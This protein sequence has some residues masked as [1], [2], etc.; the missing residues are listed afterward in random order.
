MV[1]NVIPF[2]GKFFAES[3]RTSQRRS[4][5]A[6]E[7]ALRRPRFGT[8]A[9]RPWEALSTPNTALSLPA[10]IHLA[11]AHIDLEI[12][13]LTARARLHRLMSKALG[14]NN[15]SLSTNAYPA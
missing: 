6:E 13:H 12:S 15:S 3:S 11:V 4:P 1:N 9:D 7:S 8:R 5:S 2:P 10:Q 14:T